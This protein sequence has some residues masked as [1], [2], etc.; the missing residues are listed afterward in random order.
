MGNA[1]TVLP[2]NKRKELSTSPNFNR[3]KADEFIK[4][5]KNAEM[6]EK[7]YDYNADLTRLDLYKQAQKTLISPALKSSIIKAPNFDNYPSGLYTNINLENITYKRKT[8]EKKIIR[9]TELQTKNLQLEQKFN[10]FHDFRCKLLLSNKIKVGDETSVNNYKAFITK[11]NN[12]CLIKDCLRK[13]WWWSFVDD[14]FEERETGKDFKINFA[15]TQKTKISVLETQTTGRSNKNKLCC[16]A[17]KEKYKSK[18]MEEY[19][20]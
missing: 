20:N 4:I 19:Q 10:Y 12:G 5:R 3:S 16:L 18:V 2:V 1:T 15:W 11:G 9:Y 13:R 8:V 14:S 17:K 6:S 7:F